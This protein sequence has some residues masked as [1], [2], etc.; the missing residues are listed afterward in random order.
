M[1]QCA[2]AITVATNVSA[3]E[4]MY[5]TINFLKKRALSSASYEETYRTPHPTPGSIPGVG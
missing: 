2:T 3:V 1:S 4:M 5:T